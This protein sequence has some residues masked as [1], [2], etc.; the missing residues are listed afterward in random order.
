MKDINIRNYSVNFWCTKLEY[1][2]ELNSRTRYCF[3]HVLDQNGMVS[4]DDA[5][6]FVSLLKHRAAYLSGPTTN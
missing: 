5:I 3:K 1:N 2:A 6:H 4:A